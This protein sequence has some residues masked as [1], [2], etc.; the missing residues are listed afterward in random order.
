MLKTYKLLMFVC[1]VSFCTFTNAQ[2]YGTIIKDH[3]EANRS[4]LGIT[5]QDISGITV[6][7]EV[8]TRKNGTTHVYATQKINDI[9]VFNGVVNAAFRNGQIIYV[10]N[11][12]E[13]NI[14]SRVNTVSPVLSPV[15]A[16]SAAATS[17]GLGS[18]NFSLTQS[19]SS[20]EF[21]LNQGGVSL[22]E[23]P[24]KL[25][26]QSTEDDELKLAWDLSIHTVNSEHW[27]S[28]RVDALTGELLSQSDWIVSCTFESH[29]H[30]N[31]SISSNEG[32]N[33]SVFGL[34]QTAIANELLAG[35]QYNVYP[36]P[37]ESPN[38][39]GRSIVID[40]QDLV[41]SPFGWHDINGVEGAEFTITRGNNVWAFE[42]IDGGSDIGESPDGGDELN[43]DFPLDE[44]QDASAFTEAA[45]V[46]LFYWNNI[47]HDV[48]YQYGFDEESGNFQT[49]N[50]GNGGVANDFVFA[51]AQDGSGTNNATFGTP[52]D[53]Q[54]PAMR[55]FLW[56][57]SG[58]N[59]EV[60]IESGPLAG[61]YPITMSTFSD[62]WPAEGLLGDLA[63]A[64][65]DDASADSTDPLDIC[66]AL[67]NAG[68]L[69]GRIAVVR[70]GTCNFSL[71]VETVQAAGAIGVIV[72]NNVGDAPIDLGG[73]SNIATIPA[74][75][76]TQ[77]F[78]DDLIAALQNG[79]VF[80]DVLITGD[81]RIDGSLDN[82]I[83]AHE[84]GHGIS[85]RLTGGGANSGC[86]GNAEQMGEGWSDYFGMM[87]T[88]EVGD[89][90]E[91]GRGVGTYAV[92]QSPN[93]PGIRPAPYSTDF[94][95]NGLTYGD[96]NNN[97][98]SQPHGIGTVWATI[99]WDMSWAFI[100]K[101]GFSTDF[102]TGIRGNNIALQLVID[103][104]KLQPCS[105]GF[106]DG[107]DAILAAVEINTLIPDEEK[108]QARC[109]IWN[110][111]AARGLGFSADQGS[112]NN[113]FDQVEA[114]D[115]PT[116][117]D[118]TACVSLSV[119]EAASIDSLF[120]V[121]PNPSNGQ[122]TINV[123]GTL[124]EGQVRIYDING[125]EVYKQD[126][127]LQGTISVNAEGLSTGVYI[128]N[129]TS[130]SNTITKKL[131]IE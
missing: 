29:N 107:R 38:H 42:D 67:T 15:Q 40:P 61:A 74:G 85:T 48:F 45:T 115:V 116:N 125:R 88:M 124:G 24:V 83:I 84:Y 92:N 117:E 87:L 34:N 119:D 69:D 71:K 12:L 62:N 16:A 9:E 104:L 96:T 101:Y 121:F 21:V 109:T 20:N 3:L 14:A 30:R 43:F 31:I 57:T 123:T 113:R 108:D 39:G 33:T 90:P 1:A 122:I 111:F 10:S 6:T 63:L 53:G 59:A 100:D 73:D 5:N 18:S 54:N 77:A 52:P 120:N 102:H 78:G 68:D 82:G 75:M 37:V 49:N 44:S 126:A 86:L 50:Y 114:F 66:D 95:V 128:M 41:A 27:Y 89:T 72:V 11:S 93:G 60:N 4:S 127:T 79:E 23:V 19:I 129:I 98:I 106:V 22:E 110:V 35:E 94:A 51:L 2:D 81:R 99:L 17:L 46:N 131:I 58:E 91:Q 8:L 25:V 76:V 70:R 28:V 97:Q 47:M 65:D 56:T 105:P 13:K 32:G 64:M 7:N 55:M 130:D 80:N 26:Y 112:S 103:G 118:G 36:I